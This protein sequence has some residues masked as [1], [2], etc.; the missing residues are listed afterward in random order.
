MWNCCVLGFSQDGEEGG[1]GI[2][3]DGGVRWELIIC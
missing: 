2:G 1:G 3:G